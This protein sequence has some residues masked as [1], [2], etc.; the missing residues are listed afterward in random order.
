MSCKFIDVDEE[1]SNISRGS[2]N[3]VVSWAIIVGLLYNYVD[4]IS[5]LSDDIESP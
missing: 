5:F 2:R 1:C 4:V 3:N